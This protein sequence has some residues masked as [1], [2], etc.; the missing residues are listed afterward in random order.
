MGDQPEWAR[1]LENLMTTITTDVG[2]LGTEVQAVRTM[3][4]NLSAE[5]QAVRTDLSNQIHTHACRCP[6]SAMHNLSDAATAVTG[7][8]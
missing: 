7:H 4:T 8:P 2:N 1:R 5:L 3:Q 6:G